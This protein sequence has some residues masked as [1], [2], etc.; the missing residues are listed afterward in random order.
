M[1]KVELKQSIHRICYG[2]KIL[3]FCEALRYVFRGE[4]N[5]TFWGLIAI[6][7]LLLIALHIWENKDYSV[8]MYPYADD[9]YE[10]YDEEDIEEDEDEAERK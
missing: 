6:Y 2:M 8:R 3:T 4:C 10:E 7:F 1:K 5:F 9:E